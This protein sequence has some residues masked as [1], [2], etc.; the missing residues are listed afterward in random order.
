[1]S[2]KKEYGGLG[3]PSLA[4][5]NM[6]LLAT[7]IKRYQLDEYKIWKQIIDHKYRVNNPNIFACSSFGASPFWKGFVWATEAAKM[8]SNGEL[9]MGGI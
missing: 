9:G 3:I 2:Q 8:G 7:W 4:K 1:V 5:M 6:C